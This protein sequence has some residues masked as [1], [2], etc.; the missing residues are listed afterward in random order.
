MV[1]IRLPIIRHCSGMAPRGWHAWGHKVSSV[2]EFI[3]D[4]SC[5]VSKM[6]RVSWQLFLM[7][8]TKEL[9]KLDILL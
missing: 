4:D 8:S 6:E 5:I 7:K 2:P 9:L 3:S 1:G